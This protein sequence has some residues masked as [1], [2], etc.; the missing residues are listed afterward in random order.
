[1]HGLNSALEK[2]R[3]TLPYHDDTVK[4]TKIETLRVARQYIWSL[5]N[6]LKSPASS[7]PQQPPLPQT[8]LPTHVLPDNNTSATSRTDQCYSNNV[9]AH[10]LQNFIR[11]S[12]FYYLN[13]ICRHHRSCPSHR[14]RHA[15]YLTGV[16]PTTVPVRSTKSCTPLIIQRLLTLTT[17]TR[18]TLNIHDTLLTLQFTPASFYNRPRYLCKWMYSTLQACVCL[19][20]DPSH[21]S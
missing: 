18:T 1:M 20:S 10:Y 5:T 3:S 17:I 19:L 13:I 14:W 9:S 16:R 4:M 7:Q 15:V 11:F 2:L 12:S 21:Q 8:Q 6:A